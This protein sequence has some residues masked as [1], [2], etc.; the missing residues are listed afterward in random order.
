M[1]NHLISHFRLELKTIMAVLRKCCCCCNV[2]T[3]TI[4]LGTLGLVSIYCTYHSCLCI[5]HNNSDAAVSIFGRIPGR[6]S[7]G[8]SDVVFCSLQP[9]E[10]SHY[11]GTSFKSHSYVRASIRSV[12]YSCYKFFLF[13]FTTLNDLH[14]YYKIIQQQKQ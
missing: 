14:S 6:R 5:F 12:S 7:D 10:C 2:K 8:H 1:Y 3:G 4:I 13:F 11:S 9:A